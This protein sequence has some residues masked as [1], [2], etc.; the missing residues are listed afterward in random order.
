MLEAALTLFV[1]KGLAATRQ[2]EVA[3]LAGVSKGTLYLYFENKEDIFK[4]V[5]RENLVT[6][7][8]SFAELEQVLAHG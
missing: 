4:A 1:E 2:E 3:K 8:A 7:L 5:L 6:R